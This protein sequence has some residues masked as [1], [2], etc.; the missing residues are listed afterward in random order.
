MHHLGGQMNAEGKLT[1][2]EI[3]TS[4]CWASLSTPCD[5][6]KQKRRVIR[7]TTTTPRQQS[8]N[9]GQQNSRLPRPPNNYPSAAES[10]GSI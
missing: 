3:V 5:P 9:G 1:N 6:E 2:C 4:Q 8:A 7:A 10:A